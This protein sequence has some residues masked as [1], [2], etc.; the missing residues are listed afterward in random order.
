MIRY[1][2]GYTQT[3]LCLPFFG[4]GLIQF[5]LEFWGKPSGATMMRLYG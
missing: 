3:P 4:S 2:C 1:P 5:R